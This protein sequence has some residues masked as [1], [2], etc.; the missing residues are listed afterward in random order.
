MLCE[1][2]VVGKIWWRMLPDGLFRRARELVP[3]A[4]D[5]ESHLQRRMTDGIDRLRWA[6]GAIDLAFGHS[7]RGS[8]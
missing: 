4:S 1:G 3:I 6:L 2:L 7:G 5:M 8:E